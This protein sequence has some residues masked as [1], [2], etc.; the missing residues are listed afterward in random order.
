MADPF[1][2]F[3]VPEEKEPATPTGKQESDPFAQFDVSAEGKKQDPFAAYSTGV[4]EGQVDDEDLQQIA[5]RRGVDIEILKQFL[6][7]ATGLTGPQT[8]KSD[9][10]QKIAGEAGKIAF[11]VPQKLYT[12][13]QSPK[14]RAAIDDLRE[15]VEERKTTA[16]LAAEIGTGIGAAV[17]GAALT[18]GASLAAPVGR[19]IL[20]EIAGETAKRAITRAAI[21]GATEGAVAGAITGA[22]RARSGEEFKGAAEGAILPGVFSAASGALIRGLQKR[23]GTKVAEEAADL[24]DN[25]AKEYDVQPQLESALNRTKQFDSTVENMILDEGGEA[26]KQL[27][28]RIKAARAANEPVGDMLAQARKIKELA[29]FTSGKSKLSWNA[30]VEEIDKNR[31]IFGEQLADTYKELRKSQELSKVIGDIGAG[32]VNR[33]KE[34]GQRTVDLFIAGRYVAGAIDRRL[35]TNLVQVMDEFATRDTAFK[36][37][38]AASQTIINKFIKEANVLDIKPS[39]LFQAM[40]KA[41]TVEA[42]SAALGSEEKGQ[43]ASKLKD[44]LEATRKELGEKTEVR[45]ALNIPFREKYLP[46][47]TAEDAVIISRLDKLQKD[48]ETRFNT[49]LASPSIS[50]A[51]TMQGLLNEYNSK[52]RKLIL[53]ANKTLTEAQQKIVDDFN[54]KA[55]S[56]GTLFHAVDYLHAGEGMPT[57][58][59][60][61]LRYARS[62]DNADYL[63]ARTE[64]IA[65]SALER[66]LNAPDIVLEQNPFKLMTK[67]TYDLYRVAHYKDSIDKLKAT[68]LVAERVGDKNAISWVNNAL[69]DMAGIRPGTGLAK[70]REVTQAIQIWSLKKANEAKPGSVTHSAMTYLAESPEVFSS[71]LNSVYPYYLGGSLRSFVNNLGSAVFTLAPEVGI[72]YSANVFRGFMRAAR[73]MT[74]GQSIPLSESTANYLNKTAPKAD[75]SLYKVGEM[76]LTRD[77]SIFT[78]NTLGGSGS[79]THEAFT[80]LNKSLDSNALARFGA[81]AINK[82]TSLSMTLFEKS[83]ALNRYVALS[84][85]Q[86]IARDL[87]EKTP[88][89]AR[90]LSKMD[91]SY[92]TAVTKAIDAGDRASVQKMTQRWL[93]AKTM[94]D[95]N[96]LNQAEAARFM[97]PLFSVFTTY[98]G[99]VAGDMVETLRSK[100]A[101]KGGADL[102]SRRLLPLM[103]AMAIGN[104]F[105]PDPGESQISDLMFGKEKLAGMT[106]AQSVLALGTRG[107]SPPGIALAG[108]GIKAAAT[109][110]VYE[111]WKFF[112]SGLAFV[113]GASFIRFISSEVPTAIY[114]KPESKTTIGRTVELFSGG[115]ILLDDEIKQFTKDYKE[116]LTNPLGD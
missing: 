37:R 40:R 88:A 34:Q 15:L 49:K 104:Y 10:L 78:M 108:Q 69:K 86:D 33:L 84:V 5:N 95:Y 115:S 93:V 12:L 19:A 30:A 23:A 22:A 58:I 99:N 105:I 32:G 116:S 77:P 50:A 48:I 79:I 72:E 45:A 56:I 3:A 98:P 7:Y 46:Q 106:P 65:G 25:V 85:G 54:E 60:G 102:V 13:M 17:V 63:G 91:L 1:A 81:D 20:P 24:L 16:Q 94:F 26:L 8:P 67:Y 103:A 97:G 74:A 27:P 92:R 62:L 9:T 68:A 18:G 80:T 11:E 55:G 70:Y 52:I 96:R 2:Q 39:E 57:D 6:P 21:G 107:I 109:A 61:V 47:K 82:W 110:D 53:P 101:L 76:F 28:E 29:E 4:K 113:P 35:K 66:T 31:K 111:F 89:A 64:K 87:M 73:L 90:L 114:G 51:E 59:R 112:N 44:F 71:M 36:I 100:G 43:F 38:Q 75:G 42:L 41:D 83:E 14:T